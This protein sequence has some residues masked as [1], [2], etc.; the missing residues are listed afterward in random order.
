MKGPDNTSWTE[1]TTQAEFSTDNYAILLGDARERLKVLPSGII[2]TC[3]TSPPYW[4]AR[5]YE[6]PN[7]FGLEEEV[8]D[9]VCKIVHVFREI[10]RVLSN[11]GTAWLN[12][13]DTYVNNVGTINGKPPRVGWKRNKQLALVPFRLALALEEDGWWI[14]NVAVWH[15]PNAMPSS[16]KDR[17]T[18]TW[19][20]IFLLTKSEKYYFNLDAIR[21]PHSSDDSAERLR[22]ERGRINGKA[23]DKKEL[24]RW[25]NSPRHRSTIDGLKE[26]ERRPNAPDPIK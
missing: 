12:V 7:Q 10:Y 26:V 13:G 5:D 1:I 19:E 25:L 21:V 11:D 14:R 2:N 23:K 20:P 4:S 24:R 3:L 6:H 16:V 8:D 15:K 22:A 18:N 17:L 9:Y